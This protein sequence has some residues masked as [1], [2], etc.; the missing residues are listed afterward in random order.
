MNINEKD[1]RT[2]EEKQR[3]LDAALAEI[4][5]IEKKNK[6]RGGKSE[7]KLDVNDVLAGIKSKDTK[8]IA[9]EDDDRIAEYN[10]A[11]R[12]KRIAITT[13]LLSFAGIVTC[14]QIS[15]HS[16]RTAIENTTFS[17]ITPEDND[18]QMIEKFISNLRVRYPYIISD[19]LSEIISKDLELF[20][21]NT[22]AAKEFIKNPDLANII[23]L[24]SSL[25]NIPTFPLEAINLS[26]KANVQDIEIIKC[27]EA[28]RLFIENANKNPLATLMYLDPVIGLHFS[29]DKN[30]EMATIIEKDPSLAPLRKFIK[31][32]REELDSL[33]VQGETVNVVLNRDAVFLF[34]TEPP[35][36][37]STEDIQK[38][39]SQKDGVNKIMEISLEEISKQRYSFGIGGL[40]NYYKGEENATPTQTSS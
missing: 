10:R 8:G 35:Y 23:E 36:N 20:L 12:I 34:L 33:F 21:K 40:L 39:L 15:K 26:R 14:T 18:E 13:V 31:E 37:M 29:L 30:S 25:H 27:M 19:N 38:I 6:K 4:A 7:E 22:S 28:R 3:D 1:T 11:K 17:P 9:T 16:D 5:K 24:M 2:D 32:H